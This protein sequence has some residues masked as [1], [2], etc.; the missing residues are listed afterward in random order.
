MYNTDHTWTADSELPGCEMLTLRYPDDYA[1][2]VIATLVRRQTDTPT[3][4]AILYIHGYTDYFFQAHVAESFNQQGVDFYALDLRRYGRS[5]LP[6]QRPNFCKSLDEYFA[7]ID[8]AI[9]II[10]EQ[11]DSLLLMGHSTGGLTAS[12]YAADGLHRDKIDG[13]ILN[14][15]FY[16]WFLPSDLLFAVK[17]LSV[18]AILFPYYGRPGEGV[19]SY[20]ESIHA[21]R[22]GEWQMNQDWR[23]LE[24][25]PIYAGWCR[26]IN[27]GQ[28]RVRQGLAIQCPVLLLSSDKSRMQSEWSPQCQTADTVLNVDHIK[29]AAPHLGDQVTYRAIT[30]GMHDLFLSREDVRRTV[31]ETV[32]DWIATLPLTE[33]TGKETV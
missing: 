19:G 29:A 24:G 28:A 27:S 20:M 23:P 14:S 3:D 18:A 21:H 17:M 2:N 25:F 1:G 9:S 10:T 13:L 31:F 30:D 26:A 5:L 4:K 22:H 8:D 16:D 6:H 12:L 33:S 15:P 32:F 7:E 11:H